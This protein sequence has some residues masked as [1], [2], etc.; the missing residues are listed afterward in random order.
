MWM[1]TTFKDE[2][3]LWRG[4]AQKKY[5]IEPGIH[6]RVLNSQNFTHDDDTVGRATEALLKVSRAAQLDI[7]GETKL[8]DL[9]MLAH[10]QH[11]GAATPLLD[12]STDPLIALWMIAFANAKEPSSLDAESGIL[13]GLR[14]PPEERWISP[15]DA[16]P[17]RSADQPSICDSL[18]G[19]IWWY[20]APD[21]TERLKI[22]RGSFLLGPLSNPENRQVATIPFEFEDAHGDWLTRRMKKRG[23]PSNTTHARGDAFGIIVRGATKKFLRK[24]L[25]GR[26]G[27]SVEAVYPTPWHR[28]FISQ[29]AETYGRKRSLELDITLPESKT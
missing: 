8:P 4:Q 19:N 25:E 15:L 26:S 17:Y 18:N 27:L 23:K 24:L 16:R 9:A 7:Q 11:Y 28:P 21:V 5:G 29:F 2:I 10:L 1:H 6:T 13:Y 22:Q 3:W 14:K 12:V 20:Q